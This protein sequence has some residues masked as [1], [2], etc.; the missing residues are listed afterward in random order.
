[1]VA[2]VYNLSTGRLRQ[3]DWEFEARLFQ[4]MKEKR[5]REKTI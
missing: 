3:E 5:K 2:Y 4:S 1:M